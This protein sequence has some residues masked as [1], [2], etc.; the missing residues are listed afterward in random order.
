MYRFPGMEELERVYAIL[1]LEF[2][3]VPGLLSFREIVLLAALRKLHTLPTVF[4]DAHGYAHLRRMGLAS[5]PSVVLDLPSIGC[6]KSL[7]IDA[8]APPQKGGS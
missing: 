3:R 7:L 4:C 2:P 5:A 1:P 6:A 8:K